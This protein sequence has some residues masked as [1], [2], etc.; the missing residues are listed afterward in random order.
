MEKV[1]VYPVTDYK[2]QCPHCNYWNTEKGDID[3]YMVTCKKCDE[4]SLPRGW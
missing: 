1:N 4:K 2:W 3:Q